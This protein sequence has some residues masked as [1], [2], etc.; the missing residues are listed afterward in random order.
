MNILSLCFA[1]TIALIWPIFRFYGVLHNPVIISLLSGCSIMGAGFLLSWASEAAEKDIPKSLALSL[2]ALIAVLPEY[3]IDIYF[4][5]MGG[6]DPTYISYAAAN[7]TGGNRLLIGLGWSLVVFLHYFKS[8][9]TEIVVEKSHHIE[10]SCLAVATLYSF[11][12]PIKGTLSIVDSI[13]LISLFLWYLINIAK[14]EVE[15][16]HLVG[17]AKTIAD[18]KKPIRISI[19][20]FLFLYSGLCI[21]L[22]AEPF[23]ESLLEMGRHYKIEEFLLVQWLAPLASEAPEIIVV[24]IFVLKSKPTSA[25]GALISSKI[26]QWTLLVGMLPLAFMIS[27]GKFMPMHLDARQTEE[28]LLTSAQSLFAISILL[29]SKFSIKEALTL[30]ILFATQIF[31]TSETARYV[32]VV[33]Y[34]ILTVVMLFKYRSHLKVLIKVF[35][36]VILIFLV[37]CGSN[38]QVIRQDGINESEAQIVSIIGTGKILSVSDKEVW[39]NVD[40]NSDVKENEILLVYRKVSDYKVL[41]AI[42][43]VKTGKVKLIKKITNTIYTAEIIEQM[44]SIVPGD[45]ALSET[46]MREEEKKTPP[47]ETLPTHIH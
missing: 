8:K 28:I 47:F 46:I 7:M 21:Y 6:K 45:F 13:F 20:T 19:V 39:V 24:C 11:I 43:A 27:A 31:F 2:L 25:L 41:T 9:K 23:A 35:I 5:W 15:E 16:P 34:L 32:Y 17:P 14:S 33:L 29:N 1:F 38:I 3:A 36:P 4:A 12:I 10:I 44:Y 37:G 42:S 40:S 18:L 22:A 26:N 30:F